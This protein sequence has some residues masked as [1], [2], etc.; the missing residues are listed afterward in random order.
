MLRR[1]Q[2]DRERTHVRQ[3]FRHPVHHRRHQ[4]AFLDGGASSCTP[5]FANANL[6]TSLAKT[7]ITAKI[8]IQGTFCEP[9][10]SKGSATILGGFAIETGASNGETGF[11]EAFGTFNQTT[12]E[13]IVKLTGKIAN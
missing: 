11:G 8:D 7:A 5:F 4:L 10:T 6:D 2:R 12:G 3:R 13:I 9:L 1:H